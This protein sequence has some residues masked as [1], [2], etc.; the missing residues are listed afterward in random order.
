MAPKSA[1]PDGSSPRDQATGSCTVMRT[2]RTGYIARRA[3]RIRSI[4][5]GEVSGSLPDLSASQRIGT[6]TMSMPPP[7]SWAGT[8]RE[9]PSEGKRAPSGVPV[10]T[11]APPGASSRTESRVSGPIASSGT[12]NWN[13]ELV[14][15]SREAREISRRSRRM[16]P[17]SPRRTVSSPSTPRA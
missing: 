11:S 16:V 6:R 10:S 5:S 1:L 7:S 9:A 12:S 3:E 2:S 13:T 14:S 8:G 4:C 17:W 15:S